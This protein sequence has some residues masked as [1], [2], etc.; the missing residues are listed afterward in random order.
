MS[1]V[2]NDIRPRGTDS[3]YV[4]SPFDVGKK[5]LESEKYRIISLEENAQLRIN[6]GPNAYVSQNGNWTREG[7]LYMPDKRILLTKNSPIMASSVEATQA[8]REGR[9]FYVG[10]ELDEALADSI[11]LRGGNIPTKRFGEDARTRFMFGDGAEKYGD[12]LSEQGITEMPI[13]IG[14]T[15]SDPF[16]RPVGLFS[17]GCRSGFG[18]GNGGLGTANRIRGVRDVVAISGEAAHAEDILQKYTPAD[19]TQALENAGFSGASEE[20]LKRLLR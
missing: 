4:V 7:V 20:V 16:V 9:D 3:A 12:F 1:K 14:E 5:E 2:T 11:A 13:Y 6:E 19:I 15:G 17:L 18:G 10:D 8:H